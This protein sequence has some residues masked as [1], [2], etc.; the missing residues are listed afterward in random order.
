M[1]NCGVRL[2]VGLATIRPR[3]I[4][5][6]ETYVRELLTSLR[7]L[8]G[9]DQIEILANPDVYFAYG[10]FVDDKVHLARI[11]GMHTASAPPL[12]AAGLARAM[13][14]PAG[15]L[16]GAVASL[17]LV[18]FPVAVAV[19]RPP[20]PWVVSLH[21]VQ[22]HVLPEMF[23]R[24]QRTYRA[25]AYD[26]SARH[27]SLVITV[28][29]TARAEIVHHLGLDPDRVVAIHHGI[30][31]SRFRPDPALADEAARTELGLPDRFVFF[32]ANLW[33]HKN[34]QA[35][36][37]ALALIDSDVSLVLSGQTYGAED[38]L[39]SQARREG[40]ADRVRHL[41]HLPASMIPAIYRS[42]EAMVFPSLYE[43]FGAPPLE[44]MACGCPVVA[45]RISALT[46]ICGGATATFD[47][48]DPQ[49]LA[50]ALT[51]VLD[52]QD[53]RNELTALGLQHVRGFTWSASAEK[54]LAAYT[55]VLRRQ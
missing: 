13:A 1:E 54:H 47:P 11:D 37:R 40:V 52:D 7:S 35:L 18:H 20:L 48:H 38:T 19:P 4:G 43:G 33:P 49:D 53:L 12:R 14:F 39:R 28:S 51:R 32:P 46:E 9:I 3:Q 44:A 30:D 34:H 36:I 29:E 41:G 17:D 25:I 16:G 27:A 26:R 31:Q 55:D 5:G 21:D 15:R 45:S 6:A 23:S 2:G 10:E 50:Q 22:H 24:A 42:A 8:S